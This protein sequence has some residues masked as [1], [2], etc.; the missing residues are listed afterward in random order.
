MAYTYDDFLAVQERMGRTLG[1]ADLELAKKYPEVGISLLSLGEDYN[2]AT[3]QEGKLLAHQAAEEL[4]KS[5]GGYSGGQDGS[6]YIVLSQPEKQ[7]ADALGKVGSVGSFTYREQAPTYEN[8]Y[9]EQQK[10]LLDELMNRKEF[11]YDKDED[12]A[13]SSYKKSYLREGERASADA[14]GKAAAA[15]GGRPSSFAMTAASQAGDYYA[16][17]LNDALAALEQQAYG[18]Y[19]DEDN[20]MLQR[21]QQLNNQEQTEYAKYLSQL[22]QYNNDRNF[23]LTQHQAGLDRAVT[24]LAAAQGQ[25]DTEYA[26]RL[27][28]LERQTQTNQQAQTLAQGQVDAILA[29]GG[30][31]S[32]ELVA[33]SGYSAEYVNALAAAVA[34]QKAAEAKAAAAATRKV[35]NA[36]KA[37]RPSLTLP[38]TLAAIENGIISDTVLSAYEYYYGQPYKSG[39]PEG[40]TIDRS[41]LSFDEDEGVFTWNGGQYTDIN[42]LLDE[43]EDAQL[44]EAEKTAIARKFALYGYEIGFD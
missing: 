6:G 18:R 14:L 20:A 25:A 22:E 12:P 28:E 10:Q 41:S 35:S 9:A 23:A 7:V 40:Q 19:V 33:A 32:A 31:P 43:L 37:Y 13:W 15:T 11:S 17:Q 34:A 4:R 24:Q 2:K 8:Q 26:R 5:Y 16:A 36:T 27:A 21:L 3:T 38:Q 42:K 29:A 1:G 30:T 39:S 44:T